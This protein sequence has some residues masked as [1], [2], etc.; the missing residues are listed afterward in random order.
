[1]QE[2]A[3]ASD[4]YAQLVGAVVL[5]TLRSAVTNAW[6]PREPEALLAWL[7]LWQPL[8]PPALLRQILTTL[9]FPKVGA[10][11]PGLR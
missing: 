9:V 7:D 10:L 3:A 6:A 8:L 5:P 11:A 2:V 4:P 1:M